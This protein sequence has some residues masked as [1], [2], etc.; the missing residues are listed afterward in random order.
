[1]LFSIY[2]V[3]WIAIFI[4]IDEIHGHFTGLYRCVVFTT[5][6]L[7][8]IAIA[9]FE[10][11]FLLTGSQ[12]AELDGL[13]ESGKQF[14]WTTAS[15][16]VT[17]VIPLPSQKQSPAIAKAN[18]FSSSD[19]PFPTSGERT[20]VRR[21]WIALAVKLG[22]G[23]KFSRQISPKWYIGQHTRVQTRKTSL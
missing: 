17:R 19:E 20:D 3:I 10:R 14:T 2:F 23:A 9:V 16:D 18:R 15:I 7:H 5:N 22:C 6:Y 12:G 8:L 1:M 21:R 4:W 13:R 11:H